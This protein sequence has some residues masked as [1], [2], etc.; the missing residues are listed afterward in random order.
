M[1]DEIESGSGEW[2]GRRRGT[3]TDDDDDATCVNLPHAM[4]YVNLHRRCC[5][6]HQFLLS[7]HIYMRRNSYLEVALAPFI[8][9]LV[10][11]E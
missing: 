10:R 8:T 11:A 2:V 7:Q 4:S 9:R 3:A 6:R 5:I 1:T